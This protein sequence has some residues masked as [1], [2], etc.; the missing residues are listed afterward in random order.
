MPAWSRAD[1]REA[2]S[3]HPR[4]RFP[5]WPTRARGSRRLRLR[6]RPR[7]TRRPRGRRSR[8]IASSPSRA[9]MN[10]VCEAPRRARSSPARARSGRAAAPPSR[11]RSGQRRRS[12][13]SRLRARPP[14]AACRYRLAIANRMRPSND[15]R[16]DVIDVAGHELLEDVVRLCVARASS[17]RQS[18]SCDASLRMPMAAACER[19]LRTQGGGIALCPVA[20]SPAWLSSVDEVGAGDAAAARARVRIASLSRKPRA[21]RLAHPGHAAGTRAASRPS[22]RRSR[23]AR[24]C[25]RA[26]RCG[27]GRRR[28]C[29]YRSPACPAGRSRTSSIA[30]R[31]QSESPSFSSV[32]R[33][34]RH[35][36]RRHRRRNSSP[37]RY[38]AMQRNVSGTGSLIA[39]RMT[40][41]DGGVH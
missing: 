36:C 2:R 25:G 6:R 12:R 15:N 38:V 9:W 37:L 27:P 11:D 19:G 41:S 28:L 16:V 23:R 31:G 39:R 29:G 7:C 14:S 35:P 10:S 24:R 33:R 8:G 34:T 20:L 13:R 26:A 21:G 5:S 40:T 17:V 4:R 22:R 1:W 30:S 18:S 32:R 3:C